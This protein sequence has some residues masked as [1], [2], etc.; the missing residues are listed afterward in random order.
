MAEGEKADFLH[1]GGGLVRGRVRPRWGLRGRGARSRGLWR[2]AVNRC[3][4]A[5]MEWS[6]VLDTR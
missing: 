4:V 6:A 2:S 1:R 3:V 5:P